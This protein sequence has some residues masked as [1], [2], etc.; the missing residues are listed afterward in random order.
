LLDFPANSK[1]LTDR[2]RAIAIARLQQSGVQTR[3]AN[4]PKIGKLQSFALALKDWRVLGFIAGYMVCHF[5][6]SVLSPQ[7]ACKT[8]SWKRSS[9]VPQPYHTSTRLSSAVSATPAPYRRNI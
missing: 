6:S 2:E 8:N 4:S 9:S 1:G 3:D 5:T 7:S